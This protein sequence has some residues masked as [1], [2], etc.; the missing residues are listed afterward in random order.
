MANKLTVLFLN[1]WGP[2][3]PEEILRYLLK[4]NLPYD[5]LCLTE[6]SHPKGVTPQGSVFLDP[7]DVVPTLIDGH[8]YLTESLNRHYEHRF[9][10]ATTETWVC[11]RTRATY[12]NIGYGSSLL[13]RRTISF[14]AL[15]TGAV[16]I[17]TGYGARGV[18]TLQWVIVQLGGMRY[19]IAHLHGLW[20]AG[21]TKGDSPERFRQSKLVRDELGKLQR[22]WF[23]RKVVFG[24]DLNLSID[25]D[26]LKRLE[27][28]GEETR[29]CNLIC[30]YELQ[31]TRTELYRKHGE[32]PQ[33]ADYV[34]VSPKVE[35]DSFKVDTGFMGS[36]HA[37]LVVT[38]S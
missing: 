24:G 15:Q 33:H 13:W 22:K 18:R 20:I 25:T 16:S 37:P 8:R 30:R 28:V 23:C 35:V 19:L 38:F 26:A 17:D 34:L 1:T 32:G 27:G 12:H 10:C 36:D 6:V 3:Y 11:A 9:D 14:K 7:K 2:R 31:S 29:L 21:N 5:I 4:P